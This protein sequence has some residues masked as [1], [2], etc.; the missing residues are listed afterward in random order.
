VAGAP[1]AATTRSNQS[2][3]GAGA[4]RAPTPG[5]RPTPLRAD[6]WGASAR[7]RPGG[8]TGTQ[9]GLFNA[10]GSPRLSAGTAQPG[11]GF[12]PGADH[13]THEQFD[14]AGTW[15]KR[16]PN[17]YTPTRFDKVW[18]PS[19][20]LLEEWVRRNVRSV[21][22]PIPGTSKK[23]KCTVSLLQL[24]GGCTISDPDI[25]DQEA[26]ARPPPDIPFKPD[27]Q[28]DQQSLKKPGSP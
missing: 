26:T 1:A 18:V 2:A 12:P 14:R 23:L 11:G 4:T 16:A 28:D 25:N 27:L 21:S 7:N 17:D 24:G 20:T 9:P 3:A 10:D 15:L 13:W 22:I 19:E 8:N 5:A 6:D